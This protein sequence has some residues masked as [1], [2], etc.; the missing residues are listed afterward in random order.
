LQPGPPESSLRGRA[1]AA[2]IIDDG[3]PAQI[4]GDALA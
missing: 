3:D 4:S 1:A 2:E